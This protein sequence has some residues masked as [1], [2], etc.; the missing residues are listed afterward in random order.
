MK[1]RDSLALTFTSHLVSREQLLWCHLWNWNLLFF[2]DCET[3]CRWEKSAL[4]FMSWD[5]DT[6]TEVSDFR[7]VEARVG[8]STSVV[9]TVGLTSF[10]RSRFRSFSLH[11]GPCRDYLS[12]KWWKPRISVILA[13]ISLFLGVHFL[14]KWQ[15]QRTRIQTGG[16]IGQ[17]ASFR[18]GP[19]S[20]L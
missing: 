17:S 9:G 20:H 8:G 5:I 15:S 1:S 6:E 12:E 4:Q 18:H 10:K 2:S 16:F 11:Q 14:Q 3:F 13:S 7:G 19:V